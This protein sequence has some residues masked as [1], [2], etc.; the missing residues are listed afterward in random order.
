MTPEWDEERIR[1][2]NR[3]WWLRYW[4]RSWDGVAIVL[5]ITLFAIVALIGC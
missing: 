1:E 5:I 4:T 2:L 3:K